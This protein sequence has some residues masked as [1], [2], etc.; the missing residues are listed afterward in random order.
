VLLISKWRFARIRRIRSLSC[1]VRERVNGVDLILAGSAEAMAV[2]P[3]TDADACQADAGD[4]PTGGH[5]V[6]RFESSR[7]ATIGQPSQASGAWRTATAWSS[8][9][10]MRAD[11][12]CTLARKLRYPEPCLWTPAANEEEPEWG[13]SRACTRLDSTSSEPRRQLGLVLCRRRRAP[14]QLRPQL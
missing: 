4:A 5:A 12:T 6:E 7:G 10:C 9:H 14:M 3:R 1:R 13:F 11:H 8:Q 2:G